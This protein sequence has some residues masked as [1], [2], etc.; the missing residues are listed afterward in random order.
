MVG[1]CSAQGIRNRGSVLV[2]DL[3]LLVAYI[4]QELH[5]KE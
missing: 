1:L 5:K 2:K 3:D 4:F